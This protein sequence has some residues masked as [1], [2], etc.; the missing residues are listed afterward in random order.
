MTVKVD[1]FQGLQLA[2]R[3][4]RRMD[5][6]PCSVVREGWLFGGLGGS[7]GIWMTHTDICPLVLF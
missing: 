2:S 4:S 1:K 7:L 5:N 3:R 6:K